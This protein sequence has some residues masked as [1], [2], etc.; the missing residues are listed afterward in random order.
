MLKIMQWYTYTYI[1][2]YKYIF[3]WGL[4]K[5]WGRVVYIER[6]L[7]ADVLQYI[8]VTTDM[9]LSVSELKERHEGALNK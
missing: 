9:S 4:R 5:W 8:K 3:K 7:W 2:T 1:H 6:F